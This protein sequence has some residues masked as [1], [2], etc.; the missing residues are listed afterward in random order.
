MPTPGLQ[1]THS[2]AGA[3]A[4]R[5]PF[6]CLPIGCAGASA[7]RMPFIYTIAHDQYDASLRSCVYVCVYIRVCVYR[8]VLT[9]E[10]ADLLL[11]I[12]EEEKRVA[13]HTDIAHTQPQ[14]M[15]TDQGTT[16]GKSFKPNKAI[17]PHT[18]QPQSTVPSANPGKR[19]MGPRCTARA[20]V[21]NAHM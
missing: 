10:R 6:T 14:P 12:A 7:L 4:L 18:H 16:T 1:T 9:S 20:Y 19:S 3:S 21:H 5:M 17:A 2:H 8:E 15:D 11:A 13:T